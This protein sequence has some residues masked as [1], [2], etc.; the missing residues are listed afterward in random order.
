M[1][2]VL[3]SQIILAPVTVAVGLALKVSDLGTEAAHPLAFVTVTVYIPAV[4]KLSD[5]VVAPVFQI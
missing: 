3:P 2:V 5:V 1:N 4:F